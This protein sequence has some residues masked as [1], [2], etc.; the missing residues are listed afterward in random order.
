MNARCVAGIDPGLSGAVAF[1]FVD[2]PGRV[3]IYDMPECDGEVNVAALADRIRQMAPTEAIIERVWARQN[4]GVSQAFKFGGAY[5][6]ARTVLQLLDIPTTLVTPTK[7][8]KRF[9]LAGGKEGKEQARAL[10]M[11]T[12]PA[13]ADHFKRIKDADRAEAAL[14]AKYGAEI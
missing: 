3:A 10:A 1:Y 6:S 4:N 7:W 14:L 9:N 11:R 2:A 13:S 8:K 12:F 5:Y